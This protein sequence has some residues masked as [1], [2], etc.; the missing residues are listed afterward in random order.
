MRQNTSDPQR[1]KIPRTELN[2]AF[3]YP[4]ALAVLDDV[5]RF[6]ALCNNTRMSSFFSRPT[7][8]PEFLRVLFP[9]QDDLRCVSGSMGKLTPSFTTASRT[10]CPSSSRAKSGTRGP[11]TS[12]D[13]SWRKSRAYLVVRRS[14]MRFCIL[15]RSTCH[16]EHWCALLAD[17]TSLQ[18]R[19]GDSGEGT[20]TR[21][22]ALRYRSSTINTLRIMLED[23]AELLRA[24]F[25]SAAALCLTADVSDRMGLNRT[26]ADR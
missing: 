10:L 5:D 11:I 4:A 19:D 15:A 2:Q 18:G 23:P 14:R 22:L 26:V 21:A 17:S 24:A 7:P 12:R 1:G 25:F 20:E 8:A 6:L 3:G 16:S 13:S 9:I